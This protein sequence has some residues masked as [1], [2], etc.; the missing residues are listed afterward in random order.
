MG[1]LGPGTAWTDALRGVDVVFHLAARVHQ[2]EDTAADPAAEYRRVNA[3]GTEHLA[4]CAAARGVRRMVLVS[5]VKVNGE[6]REQ[7][8]RDDEAPAPADPYGVSKLEAEQALARVARATGLEAVVLR[9]P[10][11]YGPGVKANVLRLLRAVDSGLPLPLGGVRNRRSLV[12]S[13]NLVDALVACGTHPGAPGHTYLVSDGE[14]VSTPGLIRAI[15]AALGRSAR[16][17]PVPFPLLRAAGAIL[18]KGAAVERLGGSLMV[19][20]SGIRRELGWAPPFTLREGLER[21]AAWYRER[22]R[23]TP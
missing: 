21:T 14:D 12:F 10:L 15:A 6:S 11:V 16:L 23:A 2:L 20:S 22:G 19:D 1:E 3:A 17:V 7:P 5:S 13:G 8:Y 18:G 9:P 4:R